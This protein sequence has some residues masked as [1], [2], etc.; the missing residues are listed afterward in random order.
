MEAMSITRFLLAVS[1]V[2]APCTAQTLTV[3]TAG[4][5]PR[6][7]GTPFIPGCPTTL[8]PYYFSVRGTID[9]APALNQEIRLLV[10]PHLLDNSTIPGCTWVSQCQRAF[11][12]PDNSFVVIGQ[13]GTDNVQRSW[14][15]GQRADVQ[16]ALI[17]R[18]ANVPVCI[19]DPTAVS[20]AV[21]NVTQ[22]N[23]DPTL[24][25]LYDYAAP[26]TSSV[27]NVTGVP[28]PGQP[29]QFVLSSPGAV[30]LGSHDLSG[31]PYLGCRI[32][33]SLAMP[34]S[35]ILTDAT[36]TLAFPL[37]N[38]PAL[39]G[40]DVGTQGIQI[41]GGGLDFTQPTLVSIR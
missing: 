8:E 35:V 18:G 38:S 6:I 24:P 10:R 36:G 40:L 7:A 11:V 34:I 26:C 12:L 39:V 31:F 20:I 17:D 5:V 3:L 28:Q 33:L 37:P 15:S 13:F 29:L 30:A 19:A 2:L 4:T 21:S 23:I 41:P 25:T 9:Q 16:F 22:I 1:L 32:Y 27:M 14:F